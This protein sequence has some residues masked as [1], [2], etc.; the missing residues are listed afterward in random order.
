MYKMQERQAEKD[1]PSTACDKTPFP[2]P[3]IFDRIR[4]FPCLFFFLHPIVKSILLAPCKARKKN[5]KLKK[6]TNN[7]IDCYCNCNC[8]WTWDTK[9][10]ERN[11]RVCDVPS[12]SLP[13]SPYSRPIWTQCK[14]KETKERESKERVPIRRA[15]FLLSCF[16]YSQ[17]CV[18]Q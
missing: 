14:E 15:C 18:K 3:H 4:I 6:K 13:P 1:K 2:Q 5:Q 9:R 16:F 10:R 17:E 8:N 12:F 11:V 7:A